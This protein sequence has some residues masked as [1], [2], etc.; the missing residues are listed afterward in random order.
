MI[1]LV[2]KQLKGKLKKPQT[3]LV[4]H[5]NFHQFVIKDG[6]LDGHVDVLQKTCNCYEFQID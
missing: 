4:I 3:Y 6:N 2:E 1:T 5:I